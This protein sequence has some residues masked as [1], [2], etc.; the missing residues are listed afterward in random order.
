MMEG[1][2]KLFASCDAN[3]DGRLDYFEFMEFCRQQQEQE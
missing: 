2:A 1:V 3:Q